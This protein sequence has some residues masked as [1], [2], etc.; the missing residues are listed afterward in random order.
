MVDTCG[1]LTTLYQPPT[2]A[3]SN[4][5]DP[6]DHDDAFTRRPMKDGVKRCTNHPSSQLELWRFVLGALILTSVY[7][8]VHLP[9]WHLITKYPMKEIRSSSY[10]SH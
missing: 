8:F 10:L 2:T 6:S 7:N 9:T 3:Q 5:R 4:A 1:I